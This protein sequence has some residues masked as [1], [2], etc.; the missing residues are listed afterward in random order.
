M[1][2]YRKPESFGD[3]ELDALLSDANSFFDTPEEPPQAP[4]QGSD[5]IELDFGNAFDDYG[6]YDEQTMRRQHQPST[7]PRKWKRHLKKFKFPA[8]LKLAI[9]FAIVAVLAVALAKVGWALADDVLALTRP[10]IDA[11]IT[12]NETDTVDDIADKLKD[13]GAI[14]YPWL[15]KFYCKFTDSEDYFD[16]GVYTV[17][18]TSDYH[19]LVNGLMATAGTR[20]TVTVMVIEGASCADIFDL[21]EK[22][23]VC[24]RAKLEQCA[25]THRFDYDFLRGIP[26]GEANRLEGYLFPDTYEFYLMDEPEEV[27][28]RFLKNFDNRLDEDLREE[29]AESGYTMHEILTMASI[30][31][32]EAANDSERPLVSSVMYNRLNNW[33]TPTLGMDSTVWYGAN[34][35]GTSFDLEL[36]SPYNTYKYAGLPKGP[37]NNPGLSSIRAALRPEETSYYYFATG[38]EGLNHFFSKEVDFLEFISSPAF[39]QQ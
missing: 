4:A 34:L 6:D 1:A 9:Y 32:G 15:F 38:V 31:E 24:S 26:Y 12:I 29:I 36:D 22:N 37:I 11:V 8:L 30:I 28:D 39:K 21:L 7:P 10:E 19:A 33:E 18:L 14:K 20:E 35:L 2:D 13:A 17:S 25:A 16:P 27:L 3:D 5:E 23:N